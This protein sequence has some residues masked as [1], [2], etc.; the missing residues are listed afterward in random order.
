MSGL[1]FAEALRHDVAA[2]SEIWSPPPY[3]MSV[4]RK[5]VDTA[6][7]QHSFGPIAWRTTECASERTRR[8]LHPHPALK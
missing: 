3:A 6:L 4:R 8:N 7:V 1:L 5:N 2:T